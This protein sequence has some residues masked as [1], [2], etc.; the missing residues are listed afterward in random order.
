M[1]CCGIRS[2]YGALLPTDQLNLGACAIDGREATFV[3]SPIAKW[4]IRRLT[5]ATECDCGFIRIHR[6]AIPIG[7]DDDDRAFHQQRTVISYTNRYIGHFRHLKG[8]E[9]Q[10]SRYRRL[11]RY[12]PI[13][14]IFLPA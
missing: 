13:G 12:S 7:I 11:S 4:A 10:L 9:S 8:M 1:V 2:L 6:K 3:M 14:A 5:A